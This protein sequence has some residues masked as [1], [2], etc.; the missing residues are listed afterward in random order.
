MTK[1]LDL[2]RTLGPYVA[3]T[4]A[5]GFLGVTCGRAKTAEDALARQTEFAEKLQGK[6]NAATLNADTVKATAKSLLQEVASLR[7][8]KAALEKSTGKVKIVEV[9][10]WKTLEVAATGSAVPV[11]PDGPACVLRLGDGLRGTVDELQARTREGNLVALGRMV[12]ERTTP[13]VTTLLDQPFEAKLS[14]FVSQPLAAPRP[15][16]ALGAATWWRNPGYTA[17]VRGELRVFG[18]WWLTASARFDN[19]YGAGLRWEVQ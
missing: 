10:R 12:V 3:A 4:L 13:S 8:Q 1:I 16:L 15:W 2:I 17:E 5:L 9:V 6:F 19:Q 18:P 7:E 11:T 14:S